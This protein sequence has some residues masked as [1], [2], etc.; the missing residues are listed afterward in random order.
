MTSGGHPVTGLTPGDFELLDN[1]VPQ[2]VQFVDLERMPLDVTFAL[3]TSASV[4][5]PRLGDLRAASA[6]VLDHLSGQDRAGLVTFG[7]AVTL[8]SPLTAKFDDVREAM[9]R[10][11]PHGDT[12][13]FDAVYAGLILAEADLGRKLL[14]VFTD[15]Y[16]TSSYIRQEEMADA[17]GTSDVVVYAV[18][19]GEVPSQ[20]REFLGRVAGAT[21]GG[22]IAIEPAGGVRQA[23]V[24]IIEEFRQ[25][26]LLSFSPRNVARTGWHT[27]EVRVKNRR[28]A[29]RA[30]AG[31]QA[32]S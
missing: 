23:F 12:A 27:I 25:R 5:G 24:G 1:G 7:D 15:G 30:R 26:Y 28:A 9:G 11:A 4:A 13:L 3:D 19:A 14:L 20:T 6:A 8:R 2:Q 32:G 18:T 16:D 31:Y 29:V 21:G 22:L 10:V 17:A